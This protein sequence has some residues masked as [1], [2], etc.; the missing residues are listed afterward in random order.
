M[1]TYSNEF[2]KIVYFGDCDKNKECTLIRNFMLS[3]TND[4]SQVK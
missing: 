2:S 1:T 4:Y 3:Q